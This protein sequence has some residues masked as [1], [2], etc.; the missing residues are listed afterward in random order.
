MVAVTTDALPTSPTNDPAPGQAKRDARCIRCGYDLRGHDVGGR[1]PECGLKTHWSLKA[2][3]LLSQYPALWVAA[4][5]RG[6]KLLSAAYVVLFVM[7][8]LSVGGALAGYDWL[9]FGVIFLAGVMQV[10]GAWMLASS[11]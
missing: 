6:V 10:A 1:C 3:I 8:I 5:A 7:M 11:S 9:L 4:V 2:P